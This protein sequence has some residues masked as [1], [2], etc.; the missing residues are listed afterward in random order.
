MKAY[1]IVKVQRP[2]FSND[3][4]MPWLMYDQFRAR[5]VQVPDYEIPEPIKI[6]LKSRP[7]AYFKGSWNPIG[8]FWMLGEIV[9][10]KHW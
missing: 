8:N 3:P 10:D 6:A 4:G 1:N 2:L 5:Q 7:K 9:K